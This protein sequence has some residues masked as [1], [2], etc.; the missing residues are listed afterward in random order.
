MWAKWLSNHAALQT[1]ASLVSPAARRW[2][3]GE[4]KRPGVQ[5]VQSKES[6]F[7]AHRS[8]WPGSVEHRKEREGR[9]FIPGTLGTCSIE[10]N[11]WKWSR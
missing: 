1:R 6:G 5:Q 3:Q 11:T 9:V 8:P 7:K 10:L 4:E 2:S